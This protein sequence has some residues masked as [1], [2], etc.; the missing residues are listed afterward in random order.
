LKQAETFRK[1][2]PGKDVHIRRNTE[3]N[4]VL[5]RSMPVILWTQRMPDNGAAIQKVVDP[6]LR[7]TPT[8][9]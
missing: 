7:K 5:A 1:S 3:K 2:E 6:L 9:D 4:I 8:P